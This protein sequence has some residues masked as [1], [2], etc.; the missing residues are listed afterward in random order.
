MHIQKTSF[1][2]LTQYAKWHYVYGATSTSCYNWPDTA[3]FKAAATKISH[4]SQYF[5]WMRWKH[6]S[7][8]LMCKLWVT[9]SL[10]GLCFFIP[11]SV[12]P[13]FHYLHQA[14][15]PELS[16]SLQMIWPCN[17][18]NCYMLATKPSIQQ[19][20][21]LTSHLPPTHTRIFSEY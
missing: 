2:I 7:I 8:Y 19:H 14:S 17:E 15:L 6:I 16:I 21:K 1:L 13:G 12:K 11:Q 10:S 3:N 4:F 5:F 18:F 9:C 20:F